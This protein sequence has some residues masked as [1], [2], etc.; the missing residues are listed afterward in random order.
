MKTTLLLFLS[1][2][3]FPFTN[4]F[5]QPCDLAAVQLERVYT[6]FDGKCYADIYF[7][8]DRNNGNKFVYLHFWTAANF[9]KVAKSKFS[10][11]AGPN[12]TDING[13]LA[14]PHPALA[15]I[16]ID[17]N[18]YTAPVWNSFNYRPDGT[19]TTVKGAS[20]QV[21]N[22]PISG[23]GPKELYRYT[24][25]AVPLGNLGGGCSAADINI[26]M[27]STQANSI[28]S[29]IPCS[30][31]GPAVQQSLAIDGL[32]S[33]ATAKYALTITN[34]TGKTI[35][36]NIDLYA[37]NGIRPNDGSFDPAA[38]SK[39]D[40]ISYFVVEPAQS[41]TIT[42]AIPAI[43]LG[44]NMFAQVILS[45]HYTQ[46][47]QMFTTS[48]GTLPVVMQGISATRTKQQVAVK[49]QTASEQNV[50]GFNILRQTD[51]SGWKVIQFVQ[52]Q[53]DGGNSS[54]SLSYQYTDINPTK[55]ISQYRIQEVNNDGKTSLSEVK[56]VRGE[57][58][59]SKLTLY[60]NPS[61]NGRATIV[62]DKSSVRDIL[63]SDVSGRIVRQYKSITA[64][65]TAIEN[66]TNG[67]YNVQMI[68]RTTNET[69]IVRLLVKR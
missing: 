11:G 2:A 35:S 57:E 9:S 60:P 34:T 47:A 48:C 7:D 61:I 46:M 67:L 53:A 36:G 64:G 25:K 59:A 14:N 58:L 52:S 40:A 17:N 3:L 45:S 55:G 12:F 24:I 39:V 31:M 62:F 43:A 56:M 5:A 37:D 29:H 26:I 23:S 15:T 54:Q 66:L 69:T 65:S 28:N 30:L 1:V 16:A 8:M 22:M 63:V 38:D 18:D 19:V 27:W 41:Y 44:Y 50:R 20:L 6:G 42:R 51:E 4:A 68:D 49:W 32:A 10:N 21:S 33:C 13:T